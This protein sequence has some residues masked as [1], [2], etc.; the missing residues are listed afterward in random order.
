M[1]VR[2][3]DDISGEIVDA[4]IKVHKNLGPGLLESVYEI[5][6]AKELERRGL[7]VHRQKPIIIEFE[8]LVFEEGFRIDL[9][10]DRAVLVELKSIDKIAPVHHKQVLTYLRLAK[11][12]VGLLLNFGE[13]FMKDGIHRLVNN[14][15][16]TSSSKLEINKRL[17][18]DQ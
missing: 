3:L 1:L 17:P 14:F 16:Q 6:L 7:E 2:D 4:A 5:V 9:E 8:G 12:K 11:K 10:V 15:D 13:A 18:R